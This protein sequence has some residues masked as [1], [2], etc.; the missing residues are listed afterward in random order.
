[1]MK[2]QTDRTIF[3]IFSGIPCL[4]PNR[5]MGFLLLKK[6]LARFLKVN[7]QYKVLDAG[8]GIGVYA[9]FLKELDIKGTYLGVDLEF[10]HKVS[11]FKGTKD[12]LIRFKKG[13]LARLNLNKKFDLILS[14]WT[15]EHLKDDL[16]A[17]NVLKEHLE[18]KGLLFLAVPSFHTWPFEFGRHGFHYYSFRDLERLIKKAGLKILAH[19]KCG[20]PFGWL[21]V[22]FYD[23]LSFLVLVPVF[24]FYKILG[25]LP[26]RKT[27]E[28]LGKAELSRRILNNTIFVYKKMRLGRRIHYNL[29]KV[30]SKIDEKLPFLESSYFL[31]L[32]AKHES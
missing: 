18:K 28:D 16:K 3:K 17:L 13:D 5:Y 30:I 6:Y 9:D 32:E 8:C 31:V 11:D 7:Q 2:N 1:M 23:W 19:K 26:K 15:L 4:S 24:G 21:F 12:F 22:L 20:G 25:K 14:L 29:V 27:R 10:K